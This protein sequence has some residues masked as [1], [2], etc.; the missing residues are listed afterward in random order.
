MAGNESSSVYNGQLNV[1]ANEH[2]PSGTL[3]DHTAPTTQVDD[4]GTG[5]AAAKASSGKITETEA[6]P[7]E[8]KLSGAEL[9]KRAKA[10]KAARREREKAE[11]ASGGGVSSSQGGPVQ[12]LQQSNV[13]GQKKG[14]QNQQDAKSYQD[15]KTTRSRR[16]SGT[17]N[18]AQKMPIRSAQSSTQPQQPR[19]PSKEVGLF[20]HLYNQSRRTTLHPTP[21][22]EV[23]P[24]VLALGL[25]MSSYTI[26]GSNARCVAML[27]TF[28]AAINAYATPPQ[29]SLARHLTSHYLS[30][31]ISYL[32][33]CRPISIS[34]GNAIRW[35]KDLIIKIDPAVEERDAKAMITEAI[36]G[37]I[38]E[39][40]TAADTLIANSAADKIA[41]G[42][43]IVTYAKS[44]IV[45]KTLLQAHAQGKRFRVVVVDS[46]PLFEG[47]NLA[48]AL[49]AGGIEV[50]YALI[51]AAA[52]A[53]GEATKVLL[54]AHAMMS[55]GRLYS[56]IGT[57]VV[58]MQ[59]AER[60]IPVIVCCESVKF[61]E[62]VA[63]DSI[64]QNE[65]AEPDELIAEGRIEETSYQVGGEEKEGEE[66]I[67]K[68]KSPSLR[69]WREKANLQLLNVMYD[70]TPA[71]YI[72]MVVTE[73][74]SLPPSSVPVVHRISTNV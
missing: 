5:R 49:A 4:V 36:D 52:H 2:S 29:T 73:Y 60:D 12:P 50:R 37:F 8:P 14:K 33:S 34:M 35:L 1:K 54:G 43:V 66:N 69:E 27:L 62:R 65:V 45:Q 25:Q 61:T 51:S 44:S 74:G 32:N 3:S 30:P 11:S 20:G 23:H 24:A 42:D 41:N 59:A 22:K 13:D 38:R 10:E 39:R 40:I 63:L 15:P 26:C 53:L 28:K 55:N 67:V 16:G 72:K 19:K 58:A 7:A 46:K 71:E 57:A 70:V 31:Q 47:R 56:R 21:P 68:K 18:P 9:K 17:A 48:R 64:V 6:T